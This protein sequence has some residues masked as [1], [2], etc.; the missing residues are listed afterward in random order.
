MIGV[1]SVRVSNAARNETQIFDADFLYRANIDSSGSVGL[2]RVLET[3]Y[4]A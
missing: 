4:A 3:A 1:D 2:M